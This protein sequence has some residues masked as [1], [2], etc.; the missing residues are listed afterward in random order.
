VGITE[1]KVDSGSGEA[2]KHL[3]RDN[4]V[5]FQWLQSIFAP[6]QQAGSEQFFHGPLHRYDSKAATVATSGG[7]P[8]RTANPVQ[9]EGILGGMGRLPI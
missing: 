7:K 4:P 2:L 9:T 1:S 3:V 5:P 8:V 6:E